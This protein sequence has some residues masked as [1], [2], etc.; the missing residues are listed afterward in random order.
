MN[1]QRKTIYALRKQI[2]EGSYMAEEGLADAK[3]KGDGADVRK[4]V[5]VEPPEEQVTRFREHLEVILER[6]VIALS[7]L[8]EPPP[9][10]PNG[11]LPEPTLDD[12]VE[13]DPERIER[14]T[15]AFFGFKPDLA[16]LEDPREMLDRLREVVPRSLAA[17]RERLLDDAEQVAFDLVDEYCSGSNESSWDLEE[18]ARAVGGEFAFTPTGLDDLP[19]VDAIAESIFSQLEKVIADKEADMGLDV[20]VA[21]FRHFYLREIDRQWLDH[22]AAMDHL[23]SGIGL[24]GYGNRDPKQEYK[25]EGYGMFTTMMGN[26][27]ANVLQKAF[28]VQ[29]E[30]KEDVQRIA[31]PRRTGKTVEGRG[32]LGG[33]PAS[34]AERRKPSTV[35]RDGQKI[36]RNAPCPC[37]SGKKYKKCHGKN[38]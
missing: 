9:P 14:Q 22:L 7:K 23:R 38:A 12:I 36:G 3:R 33:G 19:N 4:L 8:R 34:P 11:E 29:I 24:R 21:A 30:K 37:G 6:M 32:A 20:F 1:Q 15:Y 2:L 31:V 17:Q 26:I 10:G 35:K 5:E 25:R 18:L 16:D 27:K 28:H 13:T